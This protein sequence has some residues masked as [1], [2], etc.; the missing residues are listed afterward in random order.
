MS[1]ILKSLEQLQENSFCRK[2][3]RKPFAEINTILLERILV[4]QL[5]FYCDFDERCFF[6]R[7]REA[8]IPDFQIEKMLQR[9]RYN[10]VLIEKNG[11]YNFNEGKEYQTIQK[12]MKLNRAQ[13]IDSYFI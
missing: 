1:F 12:N 11:L 7:A 13:I 4:H 9:W 6:N 10:G 8:K 5:Q 2:A 3:F